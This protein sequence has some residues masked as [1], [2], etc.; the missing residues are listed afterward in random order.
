MDNRDDVEGAIQTDEFVLRM[1]EAF[2]EP[3]ILGSDEKRQNSTGC[4][5]CLGR[6]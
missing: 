3:W 1:T 6:S 2:T 4:T 5:L